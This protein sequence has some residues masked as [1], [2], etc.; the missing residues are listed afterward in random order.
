MAGFGEMEEPGLWRNGRHQQ[1]SHR[2]GYG[3]KK[4]GGFADLLSRILHLVKVNMELHHWLLGTRCCCQSV[5]R[6]FREVA[7]S[8]GSDGQLV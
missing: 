7:S 8:F 2:R 6:T 3:M 5:L 4:K 1:Q